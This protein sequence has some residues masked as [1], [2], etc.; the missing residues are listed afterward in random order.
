MTDLVESSTW[1]PG[2]RQ[3]ETSDPVEGG[4]DGIDNVPLRQLANRTRYLKDVQDAQAGG[5]EMKAPLASPAFTGS[6]QAPVP[7]QFDNTTKIATTSFVQQ[8]AGNF[9]TR[10]YV[11]GSAALAISDT[12]SWIEA[13][14]AGPSTITLPAPA[15]SNLTFNI[16]NV[17]S[18]G[19][20][21]TISTPSASI[22][23]QGL[24]AGTFAL[25]VGATVELVSDASNWTV[26]GHYTR[27]PIAQTPAQFDNS[28]KL[29]T[30]AF[31]QRALGS[32]Q[33]SANLPGGAT[34]GAAADIGKYFTQQSAAAATYVLP[35]TAGLLPGAAIA[36]KVTSNYPLT[37]QCNGADLI[38]ANGQT[39]S[40]LTLGI[41]DDVTLVCPQNGYWFA[42]GSAVV[43]QSSKFAAS[44]AAAGYQKLPSGLIIQ[45]ISS[46]FGTTDGGGNYVATLPIAYPRG[47]LFAI[48]TDGGNGGWVFPTTSIPAGSV[49]IQGISAGA[50]RANMQF[51][52]RLFSIGY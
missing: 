44:L 24:S 27:S 18:N 22:Y 3:F 46:I 31:V 49:T 50:V 52:A 42:S 38:S 13:G 6:P 8:A 32:F 34:N 9:Q 25:D 48:C 17:T 15:T 33:A 29:A 10:K 11:N 21:V 40:T 5:L 1:T 20:Q 47:Q 26:I 16:T 43:G 37:L 7:P 2:I 30:T 4:P 36:F 41:G 45:W 51:F 12:G 19:A 28:T 39:T 14:G 23:N 35:S